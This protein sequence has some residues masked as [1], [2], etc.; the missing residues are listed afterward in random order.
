[1][2]R[3]LLDRGAQIETRTKVGAGELC[4]KAW[5]GMLPSRASPEQWALDDQLVMGPQ[6]PRVFH[7]GARVK[8]TIT[9]LCGSQAGP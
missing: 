7:S 6:P 9:R 2:V 8:Q 4:G 5:G 1:M 3:L